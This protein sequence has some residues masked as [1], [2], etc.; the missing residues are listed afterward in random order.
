MSI[1]S[2]QGRFPGSAQWSPTC[3]SPEECEDAIQPQ[4][5]PH[6]PRETESAIQILCKYRSSE[7]HLNPRSET[8][9]CGPLP[10]RNLP[11]RALVLLWAELG[12]LQRYTVALTQGPQK[13]AIFGNRIFA[14]ITKFK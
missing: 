11:G 4:R 8:D 12:P 3:G 1:A 9:H 10:F 13:V 7:D 6:W 5:S 2:F 14:E